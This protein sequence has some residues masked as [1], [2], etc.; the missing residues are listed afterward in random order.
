MTQAS[1]NHPG[2][3]AIKCPGC[4]HLLHLS[5]DQMITRSVTTAGHAPGTP[6]SRAARAPA[7]GHQA[8]YA[9]C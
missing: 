8:H 2:R 5:A 3:P 7:G 4:W 6:W 9:E 1:E